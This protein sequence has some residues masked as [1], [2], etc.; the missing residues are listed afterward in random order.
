M[1][2]S[3]WLECK[4]PGPMLRY[5]AEFASR[6]KQLLFVAACCR[7]LWLWL[8]SDASRQTVE[9]LERQ[10]DASRPRA[11]AKSV[12]EKARRGA[13]AAEELRQTSETA[14]QEA[15]R[16]RASVWGSIWV[17]DPPEPSVLIRSAAEVQEALAHE[18]EAGA[19]VLASQLLVAIVAEGRNSTLTAEEAVRVV[20]LGRIAA[21]TRIRAAR[22]MHRADE[23]A[24]RPVTRSKA[25]LRAAQAAQWVERQEE[26]TRERDERQEERTAKA[27]RRA[28]CALIRDLFGNPFQPA[29]IEPSY[30]EWNEGCL[31]KMARTI[32]DE[33]KYQ[34]MAIW[35]MRS[36]KPVAATPTFSAI[37]V[38]PASTPV[39]A[40]CSTC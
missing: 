40:G 13:S 16:R 12:S 26:A 14:R 36:K 2:E 7:R 4:R 37:A 10:A 20:V 11:L 18:Q 31:V 24:D 29:V 6:R 32:Y 15:E 21:V 25:A 8:R 38:S 28:Q 30:L 22:W 5:V 35:P 9:E 39:A 1:L 23:E 27:E 3:R 34:E 19:A 33:R 17:G